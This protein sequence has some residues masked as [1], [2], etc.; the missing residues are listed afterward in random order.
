VITDQ[1]ILAMLEGK[2]EFQHVERGGLNLQGIC[3]FHKGGRERVGAFYI[4]VGPG[5]MYRQTGTSFCHVCDEGW[6][7]PGLLRK[8]GMPL[9]SIENVQRFLKAS[10][11]TRKRTV[12]NFDM[13]ILPEALLGMFEYC[14]T[15]LLD[16]GFEPETL[17]RYGI[18]F[19]RERDR[20]I[21]PLRDHHGNLV[22]L[23]GRTVIGAEPRYKIYKSELYGVCPN[24]ELHKGRLVWG[25]H[26]FYQASHHRSV[27]PVVVCEGF[28]AAMWVAQAG[29]PNTVALLGKSLT[30]EQAALLTRVANKIVLFLD[31]DEPGKSATV[32]VAKKLSGMGVVI[33]DYG[34]DDPVSPDDLTVEHIT[35]AINNAVSLTRLKVDKWLKN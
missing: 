30:E 16:C 31:N 8:L 29:F 14:P 22:G 17:Y 19:D 23:S 15:D 1:D 3:P 12:L 7:L 27:D 25:L 6:S 21:F 9:S 5:S 32:T 4:Y 34:T 33:A 35:A 18:G 24:Y 10:T 26:T 20:I 2:I 13:P 11:P 28:K